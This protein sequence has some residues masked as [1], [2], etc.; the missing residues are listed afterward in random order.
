M[1]TVSGVDVDAG[2]DRA[3]VYYSSLAGE[4]ADEAILEAFEER[5]RG[6]QSAV[7]RQTRLRATP[8]LE[9]RPDHGIRTGARVDEILRGLHERGELADDEPSGDE[10]PT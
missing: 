9:F 7:A 3:V 10:P 1:V 4:D 2:L 5:R 8:R 6:L